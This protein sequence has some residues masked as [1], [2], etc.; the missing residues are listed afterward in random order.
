MI[1]REIISLAECLR[2]LSDAESRLEKARSLAAKL[3]E[4]SERCAS[5]APNLRSVEGEIDLLARAATYQECAGLIREA[6]R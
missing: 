1:P 5:R 2:E 4:L 6:I 3:D